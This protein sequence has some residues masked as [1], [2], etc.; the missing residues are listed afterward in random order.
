MIF[1][2]VNCADVGVIERREQPR[3]AL[4]AGEAVAV[5]GDRRRQDLDG[6]ITLKTRIAGAIH[7]A[8]PAGADQRLQ[9]IDADPLPDERIVVSHTA[10]IVTPGSLLTAR[11]A[12]SA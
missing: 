11:P 2:S 4:E 5:A 1:D 12:G 7:T 9:F 8:H 10:E 6:N 3:L